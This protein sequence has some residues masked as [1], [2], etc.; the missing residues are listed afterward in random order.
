MPRN[1]QSRP[2]AFQYLSTHFV[3][4]NGRRARSRTP[5]PEFIAQAALALPVGL[6]RRLREMKQQIDADPNGPRPREDRLYRM[7]VPAAR[8]PR[9]RCS[10]TW[11]AR[12][13]AA[14]F[15]NTLMRV[16]DFTP[17]SDMTGLIEFGGIWKKRGQV[18]GVPAYWAF[19][20]YSTADA[21]QPVATETT[22]ERYS[23]TQGNNRIPE[24]PEVPY[25][26]V[27]SALDETGGKLVL[28]CVNRHLNRDIGATIRLNGFVPRGQ[29]KA[30]TL[31]AWSI[32]QANDELRPE[33]VK[34]VESALAATSAEFEYTFPHASVVRIDLHK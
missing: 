7:A 9:C 11:A 28:F 34:P 8:R 18:Y 25:L 19:R 10:T 32:Y 33:T 29:G 24:I 2:S 5:S 4:G 3:V 22:V 23:I 6:E 17:I 14:G 12:I 26:D 13:C 16:A 27:V 31:S 15:L 20:M 1:W 30:L 21:V